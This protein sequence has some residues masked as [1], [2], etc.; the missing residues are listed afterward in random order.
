MTP[1]GE[2][3]EGALIESAG[4]PRADA[5]GRSLQPLI[6]AEKDLLAGARLQS[7]KRMRTRR[8]RAIWE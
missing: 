5:H 2:E 1:L 3:E 6:A 8:A 7:L 4:S